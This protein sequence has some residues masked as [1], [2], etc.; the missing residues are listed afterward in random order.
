MLIMPTLGWRFTPTTCTSSTSTLVSPRWLLA[1]SALPSLAFVLSCSW[2]PESPRYMA[3]SGNS[4]QALATLARVA[5]ENGKSMLLGR[6]TV[7]DMQ[8]D[9]GKTVFV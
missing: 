6:L 7:D 2:L 4:E 5:Q 8:V 1:L 9:R 3:A